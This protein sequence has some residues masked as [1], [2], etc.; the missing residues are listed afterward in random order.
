MNTYPVDMNTKL[1]VVYTKL[2][3]ADVTMFGLKDQLGQINRRLNHK[4]KR[5]V[6]VVEYRRP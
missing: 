6:N 5:R 4:D 2:V 3:W 1:A